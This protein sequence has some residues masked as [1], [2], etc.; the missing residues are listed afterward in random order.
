MMPLEVSQTLF[1]KRGFEVP[2]A[3]SQPGEAQENIR[4]TQL[5]SQFSVWFGPGLRKLSPTKT[6]FPVSVEGLFYYLSTVC[7]CLGEG[8]RQR[9]AQL[10]R[11][12]HS[13]VY[14]L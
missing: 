2:L 14:H 5:R 10:L 9:R 7:L 13:I 11:S 8:G 3:V 4:V 1:S 6:V 12:W